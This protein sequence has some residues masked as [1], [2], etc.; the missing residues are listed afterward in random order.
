MSQTTVRVAA[1][2]MNTTADFSKNWGQAKTFFDQ[3]V[4]QEARWVAFPENFLMMS[5]DR[6]KTLEHALT[7][8]HPKIAELRSWASQAR[9]WLLAGTVNLRIPSKRGKITNTSLLIGPDGK[10]K[11]RYDKIHLFDARLSTDRIYAESRLIHAGKKITA[12]KTPVGTIGL[13]ICYDLRFPEL[14]RALM[15]KGAQVLMIPSAFTAVTGRA[16]WDALTRAR[17]IENQCFVVAPAQTG[18]PY[19]GRETHG[20]TRIIDPWGRILAENIGQP[21][22]VLANLDFNE[23]RRVRHELPALHHRKLPLHAKRS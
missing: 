5:D 17:A 2:Q 6:A 14:Y 11:A 1:I 10:I 7:L 3:A 22:P 9:V 19:S 15:A 8:S 18:S 4:A 12:C 16:H 20:H 23:L 13:S 21:G